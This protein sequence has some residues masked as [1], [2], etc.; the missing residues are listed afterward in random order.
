MRNSPQQIVNCAVAQAMYLQATL[1]EHHL[2]SMKIRQT[3]LIHAEFPLL[4][5]ARPVAY[6]LDLFSSNAVKLVNWTCLLTLLGSGLGLIPQ[7][8]GTLGWLQGLNYLL[9]NNSKR[10]IAQR[11]PKGIGARAD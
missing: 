6:R 9:I 4:G 7:H 11:F 5:E 8:E 2:D 3:N 10:A 1:P